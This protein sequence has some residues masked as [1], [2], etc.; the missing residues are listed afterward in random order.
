MHERKIHPGRPA[1]LLQDHCAEMPTRIVAQEP[2]VSLVFVSWRRSILIYWRFVEN[3]GYCC[4]SAVL[5]S[6][7]SLSTRLPKAVIEKIR[8][9]LPPLS[10]VDAPIF[11]ERKPLLSSR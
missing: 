7:D 9:L 10:A 5:K 2:V 8:F 11:E 6:R 3:P 4:H 1:L